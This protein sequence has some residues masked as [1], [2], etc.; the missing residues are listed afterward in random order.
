MEGFPV[1]N[2][3]DV[4]A[5]IL[6]LVGTLIGWRR[7]LSGELAHVISIIVAFILSIS[8]HYPIGMWLGEHTRLSDDAGRTLAFVLTITF[9]MLAMAMVRFL[10]KNILKVVIEKEADK[11]GGLIA[12]FVR[13]AVMIIMLFLIMNMWPHEYLNRKFGEESL[14]GSVVIRCMPSLQSAV[15]DLQEDS[16]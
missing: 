15:G 8:L 7:G 10:I 3:I 16:D 11:L 5:L 4:V 2:A 14:I 9:S 13:S 12:G 1:P 6:I